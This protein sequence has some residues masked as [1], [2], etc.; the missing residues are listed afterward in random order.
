MLSQHLLSLLI[1]VPILGGAATLLFGDQRATQAR[2][3]ALL[4][5]VVT[6]ALSIPLYLNHDIAVPAMQ[7]VESHAWIPSFKIGTRKLIRSP[8][9]N[10]VPWRYDTSCEM[11]TSWTRSTAFSSSTIRS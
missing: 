10:P 2:M 6:L 7:A 5:A 3:F 9:R 4:V 1:W 11:C 8:A